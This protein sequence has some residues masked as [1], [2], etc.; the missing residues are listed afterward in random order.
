MSRLSRTLLTMTLGWSLLSATA[1]AQLLGGLGLPSLPGVGPILGGLT[2]Q[3]S[4]QQG[5]VAPI[6]RT[7][8]SLGVPDTIESLSDASLLDLRHL[9]LRQLVRDHRAALDSDP[10][11]NPVRRGEL[12]AIDPD[13]AALA[14]AR[15]AGFAVLRADTDPEL[16]L[17]TV[18][19]ATP[20]RIGARE[21]LKRLRAAAPGL[22]ADYNHLFEPAGSALAATSAV[23]AASS[24]AASSLRIAMIDGGV[25][26]HP[27]FAGTSIEQR[28]FAGRAKATGHGTAVASLL[29]GQDGRFRGAAHGAQL[30]VADVYG[31]DQAAGS[32]D[33]VVRA[34]AWAASKRPSVINVSLV[35]PS[36]LLLE[37]AIAAIARRGIPIVAAVGNDGPAAPPLFPASFPGVVGATAVD[38]G[39][40]ALPEAGRAQSLAFAAP[41]ADM[42]AA[43]PGKGYARVRGTSFAAPLVAARLAFAGTPDRLA[44]E[45]VRGKGK[46]GRGI[47]C[48]PCRVDPE[49]VGAK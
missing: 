21:A 23:L 36:N 45:A 31:G 22:A 35:G 19:L 29:I 20:A 44:A 42:A 39:D 47:V 11:G 34:L 18:V 33:A 26:N 25:A 4:Q 32:A 16:G 49:W 12:L 2:G 6:A 9:R 1:S 40:R 15:A 30:F 7:L 3:G 17:T 38:A 14:A 10:L 41:G 13:P 8:D 24:G 46:V 27:S 28:A 5:P 43:L 37:R 48:K